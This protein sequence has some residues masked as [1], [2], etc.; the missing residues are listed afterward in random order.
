MAEGLSL[1]RVQ[2]LGEVIN[3]GLGRSGGVLAEMTGLPMEITTARL[4]IIPLNEVASRG[5]GPDAVGLGL[6]Q[7]ITGDI[8]GHLLLFFSEKEAYA[9]VDHLLELP[10]GTSKANGEFGD[11]ELSALS[12][13]SNITGSFFMNSLADIT[14]LEIVPSTPAVVLDMLG[15]IL[16]I[17]L[18]DLSSRGN[19]ALVVDANFTGMD[20]QVCGNFFL[21]PTP[22][23]LET[24]LQRLGA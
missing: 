14:A 6:Y 21:L 10:K 8:D 16:D 9:L 24:I 23:A 18:A 15:S 1:D 7:G 5:G 20:Q 17:I 3:Q 19:Q 12:E 22:E 4:E 11:L 13:L 2:K